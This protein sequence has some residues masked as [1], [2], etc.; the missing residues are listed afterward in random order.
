MTR[1]RNVIWLAAGVPAARKLLNKSL[2]AARSRPTGVRTKRPRLASVPRARLM[3]VLLGPASCS[4]RSS[5]AKSV[6]VSA[7][8]RRA[9]GVEAG[10]ARVAKRA[11]ASAWC[12]DRQ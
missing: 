4:K 2:A 9:A 11:S 6:A 1:F 5:S 8:L 3:S 12:D 7:W 10:G